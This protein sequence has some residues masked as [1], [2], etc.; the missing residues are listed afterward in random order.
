MLPPQLTRLGCGK[1]ARPC[2]AECEALATNR[3]DQQLI[4]SRLR[5][6]QEIEAM[7]EK[8]VAQKFGAQ[9]QLLE[10]ERCLRH[11]RPGAPAADH[12]E[13]VSQPNLRGW[14]SRS[15][16]A[17]GPPARARCYRGQKTRGERHS[18]CAKMH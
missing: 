12:L 18:G 15:C 2:A 1:R 9:L 14:V 4:A 3:Q 10:A 7:Q 13:K 8:G 17:A 6:L 5:S 16:D 11:T